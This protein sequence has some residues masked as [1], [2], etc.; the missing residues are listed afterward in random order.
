VANVDEKIGVDLIDLSSCGSTSTADTIGGVNVNVWQCTIK[1]TGETSIPDIGTSDVEPA[2][3]VGSLAAGGVDFKDV[4]GMVVKPLSGLAFGVV[5]TDDL[6]N[7]LQAA[8]GL[9]VGSDDEANMPSLSSQAIRTLFAGKV[10]SWNDVIDSSGNSLVTIAANYE[11]ANPGSIDF[12]PGAV[13]G[14]DTV[15]ACRRRQGSGTH[16]QIAALIMRTN[17]S[18]G[19]N[20]ANYTGLPFLKPQVSAAQGSGDM[21]DC[22]DNI[23]DGNSTAYD[24]DNVFTGKT[25]WGIGYQS[26]EKNASLSA[27]YRFIKIDG[28]AP[29]L[30]NIHAGKY[31]DFAESTLQRRGGNGDY[32]SSITGSTLGDMSS[33]V[34]AMF[35]EIAVQLAQAT[36]LVSINAGSKFAHPWA[37]ANQGGWL[38]NPN[39]SGN[40]P[41]AVLSISNPVNAFAHEGANTCQPP[42][43]ATTIKVIVD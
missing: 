9:T 25:R 10:E 11:A 43:Q 7:A 13:S 14:D 21:T 42:I 33:D 38:A 22:M 32:N 26:V 41:D 20:V 37:T 23:G 28:Y 36:N 5:V 30:D 31:Y 19:V 29:T 2:M 15:H 1:E 27:A 4:S 3:F 39:V 18:G 17:C 8:Q 24:G 34:T 12:V 16:A 40:T 6:R 35:D